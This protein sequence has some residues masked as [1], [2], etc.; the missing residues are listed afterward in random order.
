VMERYGKRGQVCTVRYTQS[1]GRVVVRM[2]ISFLLPGE[3]TAIILPPINHLL[4]HHAEEEEEEEEESAIA[5]SIR[6]PE[7][8]VTTTVPRSTPPI[9]SSSTAPGSPLISFSSDLQFQRWHRSPT[10][11]SLAALANTKNP[12]THS[13]PASGSHGQD[14][15]LAR[16]G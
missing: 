1:F 6:F 3:T 15:A 12:P 16:R 14:H 7:C 5:C 2:A 13:P 4:H 9:S 8:S 10:D 11:Q